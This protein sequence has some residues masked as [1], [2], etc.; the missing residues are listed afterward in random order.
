MERTIILHYHLFK[1]AGT[2]LDKILKD[3]FGSKWVTKEF[4]HKGGNNTPEVE[5]WI[6][7]T[8]DALA[9]SSHTMLGPLPMV[10]G[11]R[12]IPIMLLREPIAR[13]RSAY[14]FERNQKADTWGANLAKEHDFEGYV[15][16]R[17]ARESDRQCRNF[18]T[19]RLAATMPGNDSEFSRALL[20]AEV[21]HTVGV[22]GTVANFDKA[23]SDLAV[24][25]ATAFP[26]LEMQS[27]R[28]N[29]SKRK[30]E[31]G[32]IAELEL[33]LEQSN[34]LDS[35]IYDEVLSWS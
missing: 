2:S 14:Q 7:E 19:S 10:D 21:L 33:L 35:V 29:T 13:I 18:Q 34:R 12:V 20:A 30:A 5:T 28:E 1:N 25:S 23:I 15:R 11:V 4:P 27:A 31:D 9:F 26:E 6:A 22:L 32:S 3:N 17:L 8:P 16:A 24:R